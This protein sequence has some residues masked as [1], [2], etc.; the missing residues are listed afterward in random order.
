MPAQLTKEEAHEFIDRGARWVYLTTIGKD[1]YPHTVPV[2]HFRIGDDLYAGGHLGTQRLANVGRNTKVSALFESG[3]SMQDIKGVLVQGEVALT[4]G[5][6]R[7]SCA[8]G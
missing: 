3:S 6:P 5:S 4:A 2:G 1:G 7:W 8:A